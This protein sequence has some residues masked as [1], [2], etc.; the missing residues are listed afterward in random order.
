MTKNTDQ[1]FESIRVV[2]GLISSKV[3]QD[4]RR[5]A[6]PGQSKEHYQIEP[7][8]TFNDDIGRYWRIA[9]ARWQEFQ[10]QCQRQDISSNSIAQR[11]WLIPLLEKVLGYRLE[12]SEPVLLGEREFPVTHTAFNHAVPLVLCGANFDLDKGDAIFGQEGHKRSPMGL[13]QEYLNAQS[14]ALWAIASNGQYLRLLRDN[15]AMTRP[16]YIEVDFARMFEEDNYADF[17]TFWLT[18]HS[19]RLEPQNNQPEQCWLEQWRGKG[20]DE[21]ERALDK[22]RYGVA[23]ALRQLG[24]GFVSHKN[25]QALRDKL[26]NG[27]LTTDAYFQQV[28]RL[29]Y[30]FLFLLT[31]EDRNVALLPGDY[32]GHNYTE[33]RKLY[34]QGYALS[35]LREKARLKRHYDIYGDAWQQLL[36]TFNGFAEGQPLLAQPALGGLF[37]KDQCADIEAC[38]LQNR[39]LFSALFNLCYFEHNRVLARINY[40]DMDTE[41]FGSVYESLLE[42]IPQLSTEGTWQFSF[43]GDAEDEKSASGHSRK[44]TGSYY[45]PDSLVQELIKSALEPVIADRLKV[46]PQQPRDALLSI[47]ICD[48]ACGSGHFLLAAARRVATELAKIDA[49]S[50]QATEEH[51]RHAIRDVVRHCIYG[52]DLNPMAVELCKTGLWLESIE[53]GKPLN[54]LDTHIQNGNALVGVLDNTILEKGIPSEA[55]K[56][57]TGDDKKVVAEL[58][59]QNTAALKRTKAGDKLAVSLRQIPQHIGA[60]EAMPENTVAEVE[61]KRKAFS[62]AI[63]EQSYQALR[64]KEDSFTAAFFATKTAETFEAVPTSAHLILLAEDQPL[65]D[66]MLAN[67]QQLAADHKFFH[68]P[69]AFPKIFGD[70]SRG[71]FDVMLGNPPW[72]RIK[73]QEQEF[74]AP[75]APEIAAA[76]NAAERTR[77]INALNKSSNWSARN[78]YR[79]FE[80]AKQGAEGASAFARLSGR[81][82]LAGRGDV[83][84][85]AIFAEHF[86]KGINER[87]R[88]GVIVPTGIATDDSKKQIFDYL[89]MS[90]KLISIVGFDNQLKV[91]PGVHPDTPFGLCTFGASSSQADLRFYLLKTEQLCDINRKFVLSN[92]EFGLINPNTRTCPVF[93]SQKDAELTKKIYHAAPVLI[94][95]AQG[96]QLEEN[97]WGIK[98]QT[99]FHMSS[100]S[101]LFIGPEQIKSANENLLPLY[102][103]K[104]MHHYDHRWA[105][106]E[107]DGI[108]SRDCTLMEKKNPDYKNLPRYWVPENEVTL[109]TT[110]APNAVIDSLKKYRAEPSPLQWTNVEKVVK[111]WMAGFLLATGGGEQ[112]IENL[113]GEALRQNSGDMFS[114]GLSPLAAN[115]DQIQKESPLYIEEY[116]LLSRALECCEIE[117]TLWKVLESR[118]PKYL[119]GFRDI[120]NATNERTVIA[121]MIPFSGVGNN[122]PLIINNSGVHPKKWACLLGNLISL[123]F[124]FVARHKVGGTHLNF[125][126]IKQLPVLK[127]NQYDDK[128]VDF[129][130]PRVLELTYTAHNLKPF[131]E[132]LGYHGEPFKFNP[133]RRHRIKCE[134]DAYYAKL[135]GLTRDELSYILDP[136]DVMGEDYPSETF[137][138]LKNKELKEFDE[139]RTQRLVLE[140]W[141]KL[142]AGTLEST[143]IE[144]DTNSF[145]SVVDAIDTK[146]LLNNCWQRPGADLQAETTLQLSAILRTCG[147][148]ISINNAR[149]ALL[150]AVEPRVLTPL[151]KPELQAEWQRLNGPEAAT[152]AEGITRLQP[153]AQGH[154]GAAIRQ[155]RSS[156]LLVENLQERTWSP[157]EGLND[158]P[159]QAWAEGR[160][161]FVLAWL[162]SG[163]TV[164]DVV[165]ELPQELRGWLNENVA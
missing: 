112:T 10:L 31:A 70:E 89:V 3:L 78:L 50:D 136:A 18:L 57:L 5:F 40:R 87:G 139:Y 152:V 93:R 46:N 14:A 29:V 140:A 142:E 144:L 126:I 121:G 125:F 122:L 131:G 45:T 85:Y 95:E 37:A 76:K 147:A 149:L 94:R 161:G 6:L 16:A 15:P 34:E 137:R 62:S 67:I 27:D 38:E 150:V 117:H 47:T 39:Y 155:L 88:S 133:D 160:A 35:Q 138:V 63:S 77:M 102:E 24:T 21:G 8:L 143:P 151:L 92:H 81:F 20:Q 106:Y 52:V 19:T 73:L 154:W 13:L 130:V 82:P 44:L 51:Y 96:K 99:M 159:S 165:S 4:A 127:P 28:L 97:T 22:L 132:D 124:D 49:G 86:A 53:P 105:S 61:A 116:D 72:E 26:A 58:K 104:L 128:A 115:A 54:F 134:L 123:P 17:A 157:G 64:L 163:I 65:P 68:W 129:I 119:L 164:M 107:A 11:E 91:F 2:G 90:R 60:V 48:P 59:K 101:G 118:R 113:L 111:Q 120:T 158:F 23:D 162:N 83:N 114:S 30:R 100:D 42:L 98:F 9:Q 12:V 156:G 55:Y 110:T 153:N 32:E 141:N 103:A 43:M 7:G 69:L 135:Y 148:S 109:R 41:E 80:I 84:L 25:N 74:F 75:L 33:A 108:S 79:Q 56:P 145:I 146:T 36:I 1:A 71:G 66:I